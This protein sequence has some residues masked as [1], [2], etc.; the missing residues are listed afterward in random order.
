[1]FGANALREKFVTSTENDIMKT[2]DRM[3]MAQG[4][5]DE[6]NTLEIERLRAQN[7]ILMQSIATANAAMTSAPSW[8]EMHRSAQQALQAAMNA[9]EALEAVE[10]QQE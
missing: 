3:R 10:Q 6:D 2:I 9:L 5:S 8:H 1:M 4:T 7:A